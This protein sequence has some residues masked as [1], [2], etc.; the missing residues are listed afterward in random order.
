[1]SDIPALD[2]VRGPSRVRIE[3]LARYSDFR[4]FMVDTKTIIR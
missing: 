4:Q 2:R 1:V 3:G